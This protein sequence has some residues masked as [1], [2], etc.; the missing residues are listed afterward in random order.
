MNE[1]SGLLDE[2]GALE[3]RLL[4]LGLPE[5]TSSLLDYDLTLQQIRVFA[6]VYAHG[7][8]PINAVAEALGIKPN[9]ATGIIQRLV[10]RGL[11]ER[12]EDPGDRRVRLLTVTDRGVALV[13]EL[14][15]I[16]LAKRRS[17]L[18]RLSDEQLHQFRELLVTM[19][20]P[21]RG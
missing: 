17:A 7:Q 9:V 2:I 3:I 6:F 8:T 5:E 21:Q 10:D 16:I 19:N 18:E 14:G 11:I 15:G 4:A 1:R 20:L 12:R 13:D